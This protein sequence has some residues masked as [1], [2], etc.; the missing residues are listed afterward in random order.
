MPAKHRPC[1]AAA[2]SG[3]LLTRWRVGC[4]SF[5]LLS[6]AAR[7]V[8]I[9]TTTN[10]RSVPANQVRDR[11][12]ASCTSAVAWI[13][14]PGF[15][16][17]N[18]TDASFRNLSY[19]NGNKCSA[20]DG[21]PDSICDRI[22]VTS[23]IVSAHIYRMLVTH[24]CSSPFTRLPQTAKPNGGVSTIYLL[25]KGSFSGVRSP[26]SAP[27]LSAVP[28]FVELMNSNATHLACVD[29]TNQQHLMAR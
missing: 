10:L 26:I 22:R 5:R 19:T 17:A 12:Y 4:S 9:P 3:G 6:H 14:W 25:E 13:V 16:W 2:R 28:Q 7:L 29:L 11:R 8:R 18:F 15:S 1:L 24:D 20:A 23:D 21:S 27:S